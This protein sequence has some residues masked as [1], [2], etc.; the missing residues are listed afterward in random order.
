MCNPQLVGMAMMAAAS[1]AQA[2][3]SNDAI[4]EQQD[5]QNRAAQISAAAREEERARQQR[6]EDESIGVLESALREVSPVAVAENV[7]ESVEQDTAGVVSAGETALIPILSAQS[8]DSGV[9]ESASREI[10]D[11]AKRTREL[12]AASSVLASQDRQFANMGDAL[13]GSGREI[14]NINSNR[15]SS[16]NVASFEA[17]VPVPGVTPSQ[18]VL[19]ALLGAAGQ[20]TAGFGGAQ[21]AAPSD[22]GTLTS[23]LGNS[24]LGSLRIRGFS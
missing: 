9:A 10:A 21:A 4:A 8:Q 6:F 19:P 24:N 14:Q 12:L 5:Q 16:A 7:E 3:Q 15:R 17:S 2:K 13:I 18:S 11:R 23:L 22:Q 20:A 1:A